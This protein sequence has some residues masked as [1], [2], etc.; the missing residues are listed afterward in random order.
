MVAA[1]QVVED[2]ICQCHSGVARAITDIE[3]KQRARDLVMDKLFDLIGG[4]VPQKMFYVLITVLLVVFSG[5]CSIQVATLMKLSEVDKSMA[6]ITAM[7]KQEVMRQGAVDG[8]G[9][10]DK[11]P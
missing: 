6:V 1:H 10:Y 3:A 7:V 4:K 5:L 8:S 2:G 9:Y 11:R